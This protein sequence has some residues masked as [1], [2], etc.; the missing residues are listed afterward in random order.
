ANPLTQIVFAKTKGNPF[1]THQFIKSLHSDGLI[2][3]NFE[4]GYWQC[5]IPKVKALALTDDV[6][7]FMALQLMK[8]PSH[9]QKLLKLA[10]CIGNEF[11]LKTLTI[12]HEESAVDTA[13]DLWQ[14]LVEGLVFTQ[15]EF[16][17][18]SD[19]DS[20]THKA[21]NNDKESSQLPK[22]KFVH[23]RVQQAAYSLI[24]EENK[25][26]IHL[27]IGK[28]LLRSIPVAKQEEKI[29]DLV[30][31]F[32]MAL[33]L[34]TLQTERDELARMNLVAGRK[35]LAS[36]AYPA[37]VKYLSTGI[38]LLTDDSWERKYELA[39]GL[40]ETAAEAAYLAG[41]FEQTEQFAEVVLTR[42]KTLLE[43]VK[44]YEVKIQ[45]DGAQN[46]ALKAVNTALTVLKQLGLEFPENPS[47]S[48]VQLAMAEIAS[49][50]SGRSIEGLINLSE[51]RESQPL[52]AMRI[53]S[54]TISPA[55][56]S[57]PQLFPLIIFKQINLSL[58]HGNVPLSAFAYVNYGVILCSIVGNIELGYQF[59]KLAL[60]LLDK[61]NA[62][63]VK[64]KIMNAFYVVI[65]HWKEPA[66]EIL[67]PLLKVYAA[68]METGDLEFAAFALYNYS[69]SSYFIGRE[70]TGLKEDMATYS[71]AI[72]QI[73]QE[74]VL[75]WIAIYQQSVLNLL[76][77]V[78]N[79]CRLISESYDEDKMLPIHLEAKDKFGL[80]YLF[81]S[82]LHLCY[83]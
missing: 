77:T 80:L 14:A 44:V 73:K 42:A 61:F 3:F 20:N 46:Q 64:A 10:A 12:I 29:F 81:F 72:G 59:G 52:A 65:W 71:H 2:A 7:E 50:L 23:D 79:P 16:Y 76:G 48:D 49:L 1:F 17:K 24:P 6:V 57:V 37:A 47:Q 58:K 55:Y 19:K 51:M 43:K 60:N 83:L 41:D 27:K 4:L 13:S 38:E 53:L 8:L 11:D 28:L 15:A 40:Y 62:T 36:T 32:N 5:D 69:Y 74:T 54:S 9:T 33:P 67:K 68:G 25:Q 26:S 66:R 56:Q 78:E 21:I 39:L 18:L 70:L 34:I 45:A 75:N 63:E 35:A 82:K 22:Y 31:Q 30:N